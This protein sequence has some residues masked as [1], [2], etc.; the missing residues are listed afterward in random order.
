M[1]NEQNTVEGPIP[2]PPF[3]AREGGDIPP[4][5]EEPKADIMLEY[6]SS[7]TIRGVSI[8]KLGKPP[9]LFGKGIVELWN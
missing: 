9:S 7:S 2:P 4:S 3:P 5:R 6:Q 1:F 8:I